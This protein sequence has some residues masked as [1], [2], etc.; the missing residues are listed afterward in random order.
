GVGGEVGGARGGGGW[1]GG[2]G[3]G[4]PAG[5]SVGARAGAAGVTVTYRLVK[6]A[7]KSARPA[8]GTPPPGMKAMYPG[9]AVLNDFRMAGPSRAKISAN[10][11][12]PTGTGSRRESTTA[13][14]SSVSHDGML[15][16]AAMWST[17]NAE[18][19]RIQPSSSARLGSG[20]ELMRPF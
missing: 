12:P 18:Q 17:T 20:D 15:P 9:P 6:Q 1:V 11:R 4:W 13:A 19:A 3:S 2:G 5:A 10:A 14:A 8:D 16:R 7:T